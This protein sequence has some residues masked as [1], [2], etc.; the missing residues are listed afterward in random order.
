MIDPTHADRANRL[1]VDAGREIGPTNPMKWKEDWPAA[2]RRLAALWH[3]EMLDRPCISVEAP[4]AATSPPPVPAPAEDEARWLDPA[5][6]VAVVQRKLASTWFGGEAVPSSLLMANW[7]L[8]L[9]G[10]PKF[11][12]ATIWFETRPVDFSRPAP[13]RHDPG[14]VWVEKYRALLL[15]LCE[16]AGR[17]EF[18]VGQPGGLPANDLLSMQMG[19]EAFML[20]MMDHPDWLADAILAGAQDQLRVRREFQ[21][22]MRA[23]HDFWYG[24][25][26]WMAFW[27]PEPF[28]TTQSDVSCMLSPAMFE[29]FVVPE[30][31]VYG[32]EHGALWYHLDGGNARQHLPRL[33]SLP[34]LRV[35]QYT[36]APGEPPNGPGHLDLYRQIQA[37]GRIVHISLPW[38][39][40]EPLVRQLD[41]GLLMLDTGCSN[42]DEGERLLEQSATWANHRRDKKK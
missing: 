39:N 2:Q 6:R 30:L 18:L 33:L 29:R 26:G 35:V 37:A 20:A 9:G 3:G 14:S 19:T 5:H 36:P 25:A 8:C 27:A 40:V 17:N 13:F 10:T 15:A 1:P 24:N 28:T 41:P 16:A 4:R 38:Q 21:S 23:R 42:R 34:Y 32:Q 11:D 7:V 22:L 31:D 12:P